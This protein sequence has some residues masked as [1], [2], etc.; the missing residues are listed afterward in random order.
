MILANC[1]DLVEKQDLVLGSPRP[2]SATMSAGPQDQQTPALSASSGSDTRIS[3]QANSDDASLAEPTTYKG[4]SSFVRPPP[5]RKATLSL[6]KGAVVINFENAELREVVRIVLGD[7]LKVNYIYDP[8]V[9]GIVSLQTTGELPINAL[10][11]TL[12]TLLRMNGAALIIEDGVYRVV[13]ANEA[14]RGNL[15]PE[16]GGPSNE[17]LPPGYAVRIVPLSFIS[18]IQ[19]EKILEPFL[20]PGGILRI[21]ADRNILLLAGT[22]VELRRLLDTISVFDVD[23]LAGMSVGIFPLEHVSPET[24]IPELDVVFGNDADGPLAGMFRLVPIK[25]LNA[26]LVVTSNSRYL[27][28]AEEWI[29]RLDRGSA[30]GQNLYVYYLNNGKASEIAT[31]LNEIFAGQDRRES[32]IQPGQV[33]PGLDPVELAGAKKEGR[34]TGAKAPLTTPAPQTNSRGRRTSEGL[35]YQEGAYIRIIADEINNALLILASQRD[36]R[37]VEAAVRKL[38]IVPLQVLVEATIA[39]VTLTNSLRY[40]VQWFF[41]HGGGFGKGQQATLNLGEA[42]PIAAT[43]PGFAYTVLGNSSPRIIMEALESVTT[44][45]V[46]SSPHLMIQDNQA[47]ELRVGDEVPVVTQQQQS[48]SSESSLVNTVEYRNTGVILLVSPRVNTGGSINME[49]EQEVSSVYKTTA[50][51]LTP[52]ISQRKIK[53]SIVVHSGETIVL[54]G[55]ISDTETRGSSGLPLLARLPIIGPLFGRRTSDLDRTELIVLIS[56]RIVRD[57]VEARRVTEEI[58]SRVRT[59]KPFERMKRIRPSALE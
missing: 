47:A 13:P 55:L 15:V 8:R 31:I 4:T 1:A 49:I 14:V 42:S 18:A 45:N 40:G 35:A 57:Q 16:I 7:T 52:T 51:T 11:E 2:V 28:K 23:W 27:G 12:E 10:L 29:Q 41:E 38:D 54:G 59:L 37:M 26:V 36:Y 3:T 20:P 34:P 24:V 19:M 32:E 43:I 53:S 46:I 56:P 9:Q 39:E 30:T 48:T 5:R 50:A 25:R 44:V 21:D 58:R 22:S 17:P 6:R 33:A